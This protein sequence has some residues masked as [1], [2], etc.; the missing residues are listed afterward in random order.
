MNKNKL[1]EVDEGFSD[2]KVHYL[3]GQG[4]PKENNS[5][6]NAPVGSEYSDTLTGEK[7][8]HLKEGWRKVALMA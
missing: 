5:V 7:W 2:G 3:S 6:N 1:F 4:R 8:I